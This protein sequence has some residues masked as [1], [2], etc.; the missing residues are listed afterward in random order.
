MVKKNQNI[1]VLLCRLIFYKYKCTFLTVV[2]NVC[3]IVIFLRKKIEQKK[4]N[5]PSSF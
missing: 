5:V 3:K 1:I 4:N 2:K